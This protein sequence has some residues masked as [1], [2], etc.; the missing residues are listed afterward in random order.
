M[1]AEYAK[2][3]PQRVVLDN[4]DY[5]DGVFRIRRQGDTDDRLQILETGEIKVGTGSSVP[6]A[7]GQFLKRILTGGSYTFS[8]TTWADLDTS[9]DISL[10]ATAGQLVTVSISGSWANQA[11]FGFLDVVTVVANTPVRQIS[12]ELAETVSS[13][14]IP[15]CIGAPSVQLPAAATI[16]LVLASTDLEGGS[17]LLRLRRRTAT[18]AAKSLSATADAPFIWSARIH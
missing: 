17:V 8:T 18:A 1:S 16:T 4:Q 11:V 14:G 15:S 3:G 7:K 10:P 12:S 5:P 13:F 6:A 2:V 9:T